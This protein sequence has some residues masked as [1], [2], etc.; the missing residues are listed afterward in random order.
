MDDDDDND[1]GGGLVW[2]GH[3]QLTQVQK[4]YPGEKEK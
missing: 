1:R 2:S 3:C 4:E